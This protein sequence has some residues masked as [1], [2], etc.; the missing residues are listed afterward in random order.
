MKTK[1]LKQLLAA[2]IATSTVIATPGLVGAAKKGKKNK[3][4]KTLKQ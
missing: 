4:K 1:I 2:I 3:P